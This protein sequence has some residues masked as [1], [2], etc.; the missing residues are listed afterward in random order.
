[1]AIYHLSIPPIHFDRMT[2]WAIS[3]CPNYSPIRVVIVLGAW[4]LPRDRRVNTQ[5]SSAWGNHI[6]FCRL[7][8]KK[9]KWYQS[10]KYTLFNCKYSRRRGLGAPS[11][12]PWKLSTFVNIK[13]Y[14]H[15]RIVRENT[16]GTLRNYDTMT[17]LNIIHSND[18]ASCCFLNAARTILRLVFW[19]TLTLRCTY[20]SNITISKPKY[21]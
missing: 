2:L 11:I 14:P 9:R 5:Y 8:E 17:V 15:Q 18:A 21:V 16:L 7:G 19:S 10:N 3:D 1:M 4:L 6:L 13:C 12:L 20:N